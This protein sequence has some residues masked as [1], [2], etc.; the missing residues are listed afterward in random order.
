MDSGV[1]NFTCGESASSRRLQCVASVRPIIK[2]TTHPPGLTIGHTD[3]G[4]AS[5]RRL[6]GVL[7]GAR[8]D[9]ALCS[10]PVRRTWSLHRL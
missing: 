9:L 4:S 10:S 5:M 2:P 7:A 8:Q 3:A 6:D 1:L